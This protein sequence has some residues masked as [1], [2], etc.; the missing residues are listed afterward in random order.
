[1]IHTALSHPKTKLLQKSLGIPLYQ[2][3]GILETLWLMT[4]Q[5]ADDGDL[6]RLNTSQIA[7]YLE[8]E[9][10]ALALIDSLVECGWLDREGDRLRIHDW[11]D[12][13][14][15]YIHERRKKRRQR[16][17]ENIH[18]SCPPHVPELSPSV[19]GQS[20]PCPDASTVCHTP[21]TTNT[22]PIPNP[23]KQTCLIECLTEIGVSNPEVHIQA[24]INQGKTLDDIEA[25]IDH[26]R[27]AKSQS[28]PPGAAL[29][30]CWLKGSQPWPAIL[31]KVEEPYQRPKKPLTVGGD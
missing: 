29:L 26:F 14:P 8:W 22:K 7:A 31:P 2:V 3:V 4:A 24:A 17:R 15:K 13:C 21:Y 28:K 5:Y 11:E 25:L 1:M 27:R 9:K 20:P 12:H 6:S 10:E 16:K 30:A 18:Q 19:P 23:T